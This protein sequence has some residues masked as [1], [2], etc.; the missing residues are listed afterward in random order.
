MTEIL[1][2]LVI[3]DD[4]DAVVFLTTTLNKLKEKG[5]EPQL[6]FT[7]NL[8]E[9]IKMLGE[10]EFDIIITDLFLS[11]S[12]GLDTFL[13]IQKRADATPIIIVGKRGE[14]EIVR[15]AI[16]LGA[17][18]Y[19]PKSDLSVE[20][21]SRIIHHA[22]ERHRLHESL[23]ALSFTDELTGVY[24]RR[25]FITLLE[26][27]MS[28]SRRM[29][30]GFYLFIIDLDYLK[31]INDTYGHLVGDR[32]LI[33]TAKILHSSFRRHDIVGRIGG[34]EFAIV[35]I[36]ASQESGDYLK[37]HMFEKLQDYNAQIKEPYRLSFSIGKAYFDGVRN[38]SL[39]ELIQLADKELYLEKRLSHER[40]SRF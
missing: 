15:D 8:E 25:G 23:K 21:L 33:D 27:Q 18:D 39:D 13:E 2:M 35:A 20:L 1:S 14:D 38:V 24:N 5:I 3:E 7:T 16:K 11:D 19:L 4:P 36:N 29:K 32:A 6:Q 30:R 40:Y 26:Q 31:Q 22:I 9:T 12:Q 28:L 37:Q 34:D 10:Q 17:Q